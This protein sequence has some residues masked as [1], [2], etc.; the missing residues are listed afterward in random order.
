MELQDISWPSSPIVTVICTACVLCHRTGRGEERQDISWPSSPIGT[1]SCTACVLS[2][3]TGQVE[4]ISWPSSPI[5]AA[6]CTGRLYNRFAR[7][8]VAAAEP[9]GGGG[10]EKEK[11]KGVTGKSY[12]HH[13]H[14][15]EQF[16]YHRII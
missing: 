15:G 16:G 9:Q 3:R 1:V 7:E 11:E 14:G 5:G 6:E 13:T 12:N 2:H 8:K 10:E 4:D